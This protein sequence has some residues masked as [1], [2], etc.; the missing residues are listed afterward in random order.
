MQELM[1]RLI[2]EGWLRKAD[3]N[4][5]W[6]SFVGP[7][8][9]WRQMHAAGGDPDD[10]PKDPRAFARQHVEQ[11]FLGAGAQPSSRADGDSPRP[12]AH[13]E[14]IA[15]PGY[16]EASIVVSLQGVSPLSRLIC[17]SS[18]TAALAA[19]GLQRHRRRSRRAPRRRDRRSTC[20]RL[21]RSSSRSSASSG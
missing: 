21:P 18:F 12:H 15:T 2:D 19:R 13:R 6:M 11:F 8:M 14:T 4:L 3:P 7:L 16:R 17:L 1:R 9:L 10:D 5:L 20:R